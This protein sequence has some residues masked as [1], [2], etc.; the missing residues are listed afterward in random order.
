MNARSVPAVV[1][2]KN[3]DS[4]FSFGTTFTIVHPAIDVRGTRELLKDGVERKGEKRDQCREK[5]ARGGFP[6]FR[7]CNKISKHV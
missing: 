3:F 1:H 2:P 6:V 5:E 4:A 7:F